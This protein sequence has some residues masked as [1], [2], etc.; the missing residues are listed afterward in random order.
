MSR[1]NRIRWDGP[2]A[3][4]AGL[5]YAAG[6]PGSNEV[7]PGVSHVAGHILF[8][9]AGLFSLVAL[10]GFAARD[11]ACSVRLGLT[12]FWVA[13]ISALLILGGNSAEAIW[14]H[15]F[16]LASTATM[17]GMLG[18]I[19]G[20]VLIGIAAG[21]TRALPGW[22]ALTLIIAP[23]IYFLLFVGGM[24][25]FLSGDN[26]PTTAAGNASLTALLYV[27]AV[28][29]AI[30]WVAMGYALWPGVGEAQAE[31]QPRGL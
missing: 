24:A 4:L 13:S 6:L 30:P 31:Q 20:L 3:I 12:G 25:F 14:E 18:A 15:Q 1:T 26:P 11:T 27:L 22:S 8:A 17:L 16:E 21:R 29:L 23:V 5:L 2:A 28:V 19:V 9:G 10:Q 7:L